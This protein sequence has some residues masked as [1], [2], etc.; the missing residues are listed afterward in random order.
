MTISV[1]MIVKNEEKVL[2]RCLDSLKTIADEIVIADTGSTDRTKEIAAQYTDK[3]YDFEWIGDFSAARNFVFSKATGD[4]I[5]SADADEVLDLGNIKRFQVLKKCMIPE[6]EIVTMIYVNPKDINMAYNNLRER[7]PKLFKRLRTFTWI[8]PI[9]ETVRLDPVVF[10]SDVEILHCPEENHSRRDFDAFLKVLAEQGDMSDR[11]W[12]MYAKELFFNGNAEDFKTAAPFFEKRMD[13]G[14]TFESLEAVCV[15]T[16]TM[17]ET[18]DFGRVEEFAAQ[19][20]T[21]EERPA[22]LGYILGQI[23]ERMGNGERAEHY[24]DLSSQ[25]ESFIKS[26]YRRL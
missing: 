24:Y 14:E 6:V 1:C 16:R 2:A 19:Y 3:I 25:D 8:D 22:E 23:F 12:S 13:G 7:R 21:F 9:H 17:L 18:G 26:D 15:V 5:Y 20:D 10:D 4:Y 11:L